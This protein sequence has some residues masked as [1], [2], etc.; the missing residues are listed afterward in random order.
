[1]AKGRLNHGMGYRHFVKTL[2]QDL[3]LTQWQFAQLLGVTSMSVTKWE[4]GEGL[5]REHVE[6]IG[7]I[8][9]RF[10]VKGKR[11]AQKVYFSDYR[12]ELKARW[13]A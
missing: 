8:A 2:R 6:K 9:N 10:W 7:E 11:P 13:R 4:S 3:K 1:M 12:D 5:S